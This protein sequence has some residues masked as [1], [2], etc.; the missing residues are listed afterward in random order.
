M[1]TDVAFVQKRTHVQEDDDRDEAYVDLPPESA[2][3]LGTQ[4][5][6]FRTPSFKVVQRSGFVHWSNLGFHFSLIDFHQVG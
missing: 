3:I 5:G 2:L 6:W 4:H 1:L